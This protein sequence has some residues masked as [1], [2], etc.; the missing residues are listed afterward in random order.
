MSLINDAL[1]KAENMKVRTPASPPTFPKPDS[2]GGEPTA[3]SFSS[4]EASM[5]QMRQPRKA[6][7]QGLII[8]SVA[9]FFLLAC[10]VFGVGVY[11]IFFRGAAETVVAQATDTSILETP[12]ATPAAEPTVVETPPVETAPVETPTTSEPVA[13][14]TEPAAAEPVAP[15]ATTP[16]FTVDAERRAAVSSSTAASGTEPNPAISD[17]VAA[18]N[19]TGV[20]TGE[21]SKVLMNNRVYSPGDTVNYDFE[22][23]LTE[24]T[25]STLAFQDSNGATYHLDF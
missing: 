7:P 14:A 3:P 15:A 17:W 11:I 4:H 24:I 18:L 19:I 23:K 22:L 21:R 20:R 13:A 1:K 5:A 25:P 8:A 16:S 12:V 9:G 6:G 10:G 2:T